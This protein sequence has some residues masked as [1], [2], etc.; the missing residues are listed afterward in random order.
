MCPFLQDKT[1]DPESLRVKIFGREFPNPLGMAAGFDKDAEAMEGLLDM[2]F[3]FVEI[4]SV[5]PQ[6]QVSRQE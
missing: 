6:P 2:G 3:G 4:G 5:T 1:A